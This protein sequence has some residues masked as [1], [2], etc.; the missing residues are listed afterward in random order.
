MQIQI[1]ISDLPLEGTAFPYL[2]AF[3]AMMEEPPAL[4]PVSLPNLAR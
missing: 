2:P 4:T 1:E 3:V